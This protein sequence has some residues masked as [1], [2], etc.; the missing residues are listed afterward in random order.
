MSEGRKG[1]SLG[2]WLSD[3]EKKLWRD[4]TEKIAPLRKRVAKT[5]TKT[6][7]KA[8]PKDGD[9]APAPAAKPAPRKAAVPV[10]QPV[11]IAK[12]K[13]PALAPLD[14]KTK[15]RIA[16]GTHAIDAK[17]DLHGHTQAEAHDALLRFLRRAS[18]KGAGVVLV[19]TGK[20]VRGDGERGVLKRAVPMWLS[21]PEF[22]EYVIG[23]D[24]AHVGHGGEG[25]LY[26]RIRK[27]RS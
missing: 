24:D 25:A 14:R 27:R 16:R 20:G 22:R 19:I 12:P 11:H 10:S 7:T 13:P 8:N 4:V 21:L 26:V 17:L 3:D 9:S 23:F 18:D 1:R 2:R 6:I 15:S 5:I